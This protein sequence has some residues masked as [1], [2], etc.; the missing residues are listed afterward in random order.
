MKRTAGSKCQ[1][2]PTA[3]PPANTNRNLRPRF[4]GNRGRRIAP[5]EALQ[6][7][8]LKWL[9]IVDAYRTI[10]IAPSPEA[11]VLFNSLPDLGYAA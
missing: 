8:E 11:R 6:M 3:G 10:C 1:P 9:P 2:G 5:G 7:N 4:E